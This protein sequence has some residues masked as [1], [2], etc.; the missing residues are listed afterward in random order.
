MTDEQFKVISG[1]LEKILDKLDMIEDDVAFLG[2]SSEPELLALRTY[3]V[4]YTVRDDD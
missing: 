4:T 3:P 1:L 2:E